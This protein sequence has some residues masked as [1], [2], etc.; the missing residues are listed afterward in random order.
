MKIKTPL[1]VQLY[2]IKKPY[3]LNLN[4]YRNSNHFI[5]HKAKKEFTKLLEDDL[6][7]K[8]LKTPLEIS[9]LLHYKD[10]R[11]RDK[12]NILSIVQKFF[13]DALVYYDCIPDDNDN[14]I[15]VETFLSPVIDG[16]EFCEIIIQQK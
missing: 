6:F 8:K 16:E 4:N 5:N 10:K 9:Y 2:G 14:Y 15:G 12:G 13:L 1:K 7:W 11:K 3:S